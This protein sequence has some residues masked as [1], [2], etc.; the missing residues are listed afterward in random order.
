MKRLYFSV[1]LSLI[2]ANSFSQNLIN[3]NFSTYALG[4]LSGQNGWTNNS[5]LT[6]GGTCAGVGC[7]NSPVVA[8]SMSYATFGSSTQAVNLVPNQDAPGKA[9]TSTNTGS[10]YGAF[11]I[12]LSAAPAT[13]GDLVRIL[14]GGNFT[15][16]M[17]IYV[18]ATSGGYNVG[19]AKE[20][21]AATYKAVPTL[22]PYNTDQLVVIKYTY[23]TGSATDDAVTLYVNPNLSLSEASNIPEIATSTGTDVTAGIDRLQFP[24]N[25]STRPT[26]FVGG[27]TVSR[28]FDNALVLP[29]EN[30]L[31][32]Q[33]AKQTANTGIFSYRLQNGSSIAS[34]SLE[35]STNAV[36]FT[37]V[38]QQ[39]NVG[40][41]QYQHQVTLADGV[42]YFRLKITSI[43]GSVK[44]SSTLMVKGGAMKAQ[45]IKL[46]PI[47]A[48]DQASLSVYATVSEVATV[49]IVDLFGRVM[50]SRG[51]AL[52]L[53]ENIF[54]VDVS[55]LPNGNY[56]IRVFSASQGSRQVKFIK[57]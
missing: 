12:N 24:F 10:V 48:H 5:S 45:G 51:I 33:L 43:N 55:T 41:K 16:A 19:I 15:T 50:T 7:V 17:R 56:T 1:A 40:D 28:S 29:L 4:T 23:N 36:A 6:G 9:F 8:R 57:Q 13:S 26:G 34:I 35:A 32:I 30:V 14:A 46:L 2:A 38:A 18:R 53:G 47:P 31:N 42:N 3:D 52:V 11:L 37:T 27:V 22:V 39:A 49:S 21:Q 25:N 44:Y 54:P 20:T